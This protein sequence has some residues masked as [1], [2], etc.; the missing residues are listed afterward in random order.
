MVGSRQGAL[1]NNGH[2]LGL[3]P[4]RRLAI[5]QLEPVSDP[6]DVGIHS[7]GWFN[8]QF[9]EHNAG[10]LTADP[11]EGFERG[12][13]GRHLPTVLVYQDLG[14]GDDVLGLVAIEPDGLDMISDAFKA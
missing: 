6:V 7:D 5:G 14:Q 4:I 13:V 1:W 10:R 2:Q 9:I 8:I 12:A 3:D 11:G